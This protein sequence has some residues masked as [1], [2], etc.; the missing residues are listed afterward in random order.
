MWQLM[1]YVARRPATAGFK[2]CEAFASVSIL[3]L[4]SSLC[5]P[6]HPSLTHPFKPQ[7]IRER[8]H[9]RSSPS[10]EKRKMDSRKR[11]RPVRLLCPLHGRRYALCVLLFFP[12]SSSPSLSSLPAAFNSWEEAGA[13]R[14]SDSEDGGERER[15]Q[16][17]GRRAPVSRQGFNEEPLKFAVIEQHPCPLQKGPTSLPRHAVVSSPFP[18]FHLSLLIC[19]PLSLS[20]PCEIFTSSFPSWLL[21]T[22]PPSRPRFPPQPFTSCLWSGHG[23][24]LYL[25]NRGGPIPLASGL[26]S[27]WLQDGMGC[28]D[29]R[30][31]C[32]C[33]CFTSVA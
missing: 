28:M 8:Q 15:G 9:R 12:R 26:W 7:R 18:F 24:C 33:V 22:N 3:I 2:R 13:E 21:F 19:L 17:K 6:L 11:G 29:W 10:N 23:S 27:P 5:T 20:I 30:S 25:T 4:H 31:V 16:G 14:E 1:S 32:V